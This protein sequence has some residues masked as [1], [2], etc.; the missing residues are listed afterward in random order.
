MV[1]GPGNPKRNTRAPVV[2]LIAVTILVALGWYLY[3]YDYKVHPPEE[4]LVGTLLRPALTVT[5]TDGATGARGVFVSFSLV[6]CSRS[7]VRVVDTVSLAPLYTVE[8]SQHRAD[9][10][11]LPVAM[12]TAHM[13]ASRSAAM[14]PR[15][16][17]RDRDALVELVPGAALTRAI[18]LSALYELGPEGNYELM[19]IYQPDTLPLGE[20]PGLKDLQVCHETV[21]C[22]ASF[23]LPLKKTPPAG[24]TDRNVGP[25]ARP[26]AKPAERPAPPALP[27]PQKGAGG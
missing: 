13:A 27:V 1:K 18:P 25:A 10:S 12:T 24:P 4:A 21:R 20:G 11:W 6:N 5:D 7:R 15:R 16:F 8:L 23:E 26:E 3:T 19:V 17:E 14:E 22:S 9:G 2:T